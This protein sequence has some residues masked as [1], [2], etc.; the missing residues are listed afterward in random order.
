MEVVVQW[1]FTRIAGLNDSRVEMEEGTFES[2]S[3]YFG[4]IECMR[5]AYL[6]SRLWRDAILKRG[7]AMHIC[8]LVNFGWKK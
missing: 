5:N 1:H 8:W 6:A 3:T 4:Q 7:I 2:K